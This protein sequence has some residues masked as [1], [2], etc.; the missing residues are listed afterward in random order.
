[1]SPR[2]LL[3]IDILTLFYAHSRLNIQKQGHPGE[4]TSTQTCFIE[5]ALATD[6]AKVSTRVGKI[7]L[8]K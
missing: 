8:L 3:V 5:Q 1:M 6:S 2:L 7:G 4:N